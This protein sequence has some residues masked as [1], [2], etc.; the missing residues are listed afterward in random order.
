ML[1]DKLSFIR[2]FETQIH[3]KNQKYLSLF[4]IFNVY[5]LLVQDNNDKYK[6]LFI[7]KFF[8]LNNLCFL[9]SI[10]FYNCFEFEKT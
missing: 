5:G 4:L 7:I 10:E 3:P 6:F 9:N 8:K 2:F 1:L